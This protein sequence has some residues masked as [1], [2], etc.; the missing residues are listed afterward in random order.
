MSR[1]RKSK[2]P[3]PLPDGFNLA[4]SEKKRWRLGRLIGQGGFGLIYLASQDVDSAVAEDTGFVIKVE[5]QE[6]GPLF[7]ELKFYQRAAKAEIIEQWKNSKKLSFLGIPTYWGSGL[8]EHNGLRYRFMVMERLGGDL[9]RV[10]E[11]NRGQMKRATVLQI[12]QR[13]LDVLEYIH[14]HEYVHADIKA[15]NLMLGYTDPEKVYLADYGLAYRYC[16]GGIHREYKE[17]PKK[18]HNGT[19]EYTSLDAHLGVAPSRRGDLQVL[20]F[21]LLHWLCGALPWDGM[22]SNPAQVQEA[23][24]KLMNNLPRSVQQLSASGSSTDEVARL[25]LNVKSLGYQQRPDYQMLRDLLGS[26]VQGRLDFSRPHGRPAAGTLED[27]LP[28]G[29]VGTS[30]RPPKP[31]S[32]DEEEDGAKGDVTKTKPS[33]VKQGTVANSPRTEQKGR[34]SRGTSKPEAM[35]LKEEELARKTKPIPSQYLRGPPASRPEASGTAAVRRSS[36]AR[37]VPAGFYEEDYE[38]EEDEEDWEKETIPIAACH[39]RGPPIGP[40]PEQTSATTLHTGR[41]ADVRYVCTKPLTVSTARRHVHFLDPL[42]HGGGRGRGILEWEEPSPRVPREE[43]GV[44]LIA[45]TIW[46]N[47]F[48][49]GT[50]FATLFFVLVCVETLR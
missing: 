23:K 21:C 16:P 29:K 40:R 18:G 10:S 14:D 41:R 27:P 17:N 2:L 20:G 24:A 47:M 25:L 4:D 15:A 28:R 19:M 3:K 38:S 31:V 32:L 6:N 42:P 5:Y 49:C 1:P 34:T 35:E 12:G 44:N 30:K 26:G 48:V 8:A 7:S 39:L 33:G 9:Q 37:S 50:V 22:L 45:R 11:C 13:L 36:R 43:P 46:R